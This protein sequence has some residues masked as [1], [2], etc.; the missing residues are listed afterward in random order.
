MSKSI[1][2]KNNNEYLNMN[3]VPVFSEKYDLK[4]FH[5]IH[6]PYLGK[7]SY[8]ANNTTTNDLIASLTADNCDTIPTDMDDRLYPDF[9]A[10]DKYS[11]SK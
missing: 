5:Q 7:D 2:I 1:S 4:H 11:L 10:A 3:N 6:A 9:D 8:S